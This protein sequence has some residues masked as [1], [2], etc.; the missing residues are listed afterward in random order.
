MNDEDDGL[1]VLKKL[2]ARKFMQN[3]CQRFVC[4]DLQTYAKHI[5][6]EDQYAKN[7]QK[8]QKYAKI[9]KKWFL[10][11]AAPIC[12]ICTRDSAYVATVTATVSAAMAITLQLPY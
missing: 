7:M 4:K 6:F 5:I 3:V 12:K 9:C 1:I 8:M 11:T 10:Q 2:G